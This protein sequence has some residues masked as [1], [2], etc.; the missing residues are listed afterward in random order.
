M[1][2]FQFGASDELRATYPDTFAYLEF[3]KLNPQKAHQAFQRLQCERPDTLVDATLVRTDAE[4]MALAV[5]GFAQ[6]Y[7]QVHNQPVAQ[8]LVME[9][10]TFAKKIQTG[11][12]KVV[13]GDLSQR[14]YD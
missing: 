7:G 2:G 13:G 11:V 10:Q 3:V 8:D 1:S 9:A 12:K 6:V 5:N 4:N 14:R